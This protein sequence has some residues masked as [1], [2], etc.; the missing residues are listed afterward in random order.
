MARTISVLKWE[1]EQD[2][3]NAVRDIRGEMERQGGLT[4]DTERAM[5]HSLQVADPD[6]ANYFLREVR[7]QTP[8]AL[9]YFQEYGGGA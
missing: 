3:D 5:Q 8:D 4:K 9:H 6:L 7:K 1:S 2:V